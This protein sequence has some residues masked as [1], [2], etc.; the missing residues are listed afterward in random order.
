MKILTTALLA[1]SLS[2]GTQACRSGTPFDE[3]NATDNSVHL[4]VK[5]ESI[6]GMDI[7]AVADGLATRVG[8]VSGLATAGF[9]LNS[10]MYAASDFRVVGAPIGGN[11][12]AST[13]SIIVS[14]GQT[15]DFTIRA[16]LRTS[17][18]SIQ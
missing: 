11:G 7:Y 17:T 15:I 18:V 3:E 13:G 12:R 16:A 9:T 4:I 1:I 10:S 8:T 2:L 14:R 6:D 5:N